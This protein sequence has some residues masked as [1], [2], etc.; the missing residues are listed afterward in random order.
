MYPDI[1][2]TLHQFMNITKTT[3][4]YIVWMHLS[5][6]ESLI[7]L[8]AILSYVSALNSWISLWRLRYAELKECFRVSHGVVRPNTTAAGSHT[9][10]ALFQ[11]SCHQGIDVQ[12]H[13]HSA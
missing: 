5:G 10:I 6:C 7:M 12:V 3:L 2:I 13:P 11:S 1:V 4:L 9:H 8:T